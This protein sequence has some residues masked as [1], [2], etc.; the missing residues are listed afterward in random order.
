MSTFDEISSTRSTPGL[1]KIGTEAVIVGAVASSAAV[2]IGGGDP[3]LAGLAPHPAWIATLFMAGYYGL[4]GLLALP[5]I[6]S[7][8][9]IAALATGAGL[10]GLAGRLTRAED[11]LMAITA[12]GIAGVAMVHERRRERLARDLAELTELTRQ[13]DDLF[14]GLRRRVKSLRE[15]ANR[16]D[17][18]VPVWRDVAERLAS[19]TP[20]EAARA[21]IDVCLRCTGARAGLVRQVDGGAAHN[22]AWRGQ[23]SA[24]RAEPRDIFPDRTIAAALESGAVA[25]ATRVSGAS[26]DDS[27]IAVP[28]R[29]LHGGPVL[30]VLALRGALAHNLQAAQVADVASMASWLATAIAGRTPAVAMPADEVS[31]PPAAAAAPVLR[32][33]ED[34]P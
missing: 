17:S 14:D 27:D 15:R 3:S 33:V 30:G 21:A 2:L 7:M 5:V 31:P 19:G 28:L 25:L 20:E 10:G 22:L 26:P 23:W 12:I 13:D 11:L 16:I 32:L 8:S 4:R 6:W 24:D 1:R 9:T 34:R 29:P 18:A